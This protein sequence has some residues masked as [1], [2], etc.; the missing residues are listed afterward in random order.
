[1]SRS[2]N[3]QKWLDVFPSHQPGD[4][5]PLIADDAVF[6]SPVVHTPQAG[7]AKV[8]AY[9]STAGQVLGHADFRYV[10]EIDNGESAM[11]EFACTLSGVFINGVDIIQW[12]E[13]GKISDFKVMVRPLKG[14]QAIHAAM[15]A[16]FEQAGR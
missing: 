2:A 12:S 4:L 1:M 7:K 5:A 11:L 13:D 15:K 16:A 8:I 3:L 6:H 14:M 9:L 10:R